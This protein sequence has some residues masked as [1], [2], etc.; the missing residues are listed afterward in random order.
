[1]R[2]L[3]PRPLEA[4]L[5]I[6]ALVR[7]GAVQNRLIA[8]HVLRN[9]IQRLDDAQPQLLALLVLRDSDVFDVAYEA[10]VVDTVVCP[11]LARLT[12]FPA[13]SYVDSSIVCKTGYTY[14]FLSTTNAPV[15]TI[16]PSPSKITK[17]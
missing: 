1:M 8:A 6:E 4:T 3:Q 7:L 15:P 13:Q 11:Q 2:H 5:H 17:M 16:L 12:S 10:E 14:N 9:K